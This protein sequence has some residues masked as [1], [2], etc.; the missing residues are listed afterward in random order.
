[1]RLAS[2]TGKLVSNGGDRMAQ[3]L[4]GKTVAVVATD[5]FEQSEL[6]E[7]RRALMEAGAAV[8]II[9]PHGGTIQGMQHHEKG[10]KVKN[11]KTLDPV[12]SAESAALVQPADAASS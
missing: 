5:G 4:T 7:P 2:L 10:D 8:H 3:K 11:D 1:M 6:T 12:R 9:A